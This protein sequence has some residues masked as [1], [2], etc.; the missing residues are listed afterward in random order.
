[1]SPYPSASRHVIC[2]SI[3]ADGSCPNTWPHW[4]EERACAACIASRM[5]YIG[6]S[7]LK[8]LPYLRFFCPQRW[9]RLLVSN[10][11]GSFPP[12]C[13]CINHFSLPEYAIQVTARYF[14][15][16]AFCIERFAAW[17]TTLAL[18]PTS[19]SVS[20]TDIKAWMR[21][22]GLATAEHMF[23]NANHPYLGIAGWKRP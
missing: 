7:T 21:W 5:L 13:S 4:S 18:R 23:V 14:L 2:A 8:P 6:S 12:T 19:E 16:Y 3:W 20:S 9:S 1:M 10:A 22:L 15:I 17:A 11:L